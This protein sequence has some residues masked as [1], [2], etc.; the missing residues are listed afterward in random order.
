MRLWWQ[1][2]GKNSATGK[3]QAAR[4][5]RRRERREVE[6]EGVRGGSCGGRT[7]ASS[8]LPGAPDSDG[9]LPRAVY[10]SA[11]HGRST[12]QARRTGCKPAVPRRL[13][14]R[15]KP[16]PVNSLAGAPEEIRTPDPQIRRRAFCADVISNFCKPASYRTFESQWLARIL[17]TRTLASPPR[18]TTRRS[19]SAKGGLLWLLI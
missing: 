12:S 1:F 9:C 4:A 5:S 10:G 7:P 11:G 14:R 18:M 19:G 16:M 13:P 15:G 2:E 8:H 3:L 17:Q 6:G